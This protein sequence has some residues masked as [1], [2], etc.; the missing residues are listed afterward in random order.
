MLNLTSTANRQYAR[1][2]SGSCASSPLRQPL[3][4]GMHLSYTIPPLQSLPNCRQQSFR[5]W[6]AVG[7]AISC[8][9]GGYCQAPQCWV[10]VTHRRAESRSSRRVRSD[11]VAIPGTEGVNWY[12]RH[13]SEH[14]ITSKTKQYYFPVLNRFQML[15]RHFS[16]SQ[17]NS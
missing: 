13:A 11:V 17:V 15:S 2:T 8:R 5:C 10:R 3:W 1:S 7:T 14:M 4:G 6:H 9:C 12:F 16:T